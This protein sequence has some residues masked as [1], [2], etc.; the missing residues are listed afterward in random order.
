[1]RKRKKRKKRRMKMTRTDTQR[2]PMKCVLQTESGEHVATASIL[3]FQVS[4]SAMVWGTRIFAEANIKKKV[5][6]ELVPVYREVYPWVVLH[7]DECGDTFPVVEVEGHDPEC[8]WEKTSPADCAFRET[9]E[10]CPHPEHA[11]TCRG[12]G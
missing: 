7:T 3:P 2:T 5:A 1:M 10:Y 6:G 4:P 11:C 12:K 8:Q 9:H